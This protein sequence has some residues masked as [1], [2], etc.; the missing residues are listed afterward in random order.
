VARDPANTQWQRDVS[1]SQ[2]RIGTVLEAQGDGPGALA[3]YR[4]DLAI[5]EGLAA[6]D[7]ANAGWQVDVALSCAK[8]GA[9]EAGQTVDQRRD[10][11]TRGR[12]ILSELKAQ[13]RLSPQRD[14]IAWF[15]EQLANL[16][17]HSASASGQ[18]SPS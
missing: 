17:P 14:M 2:N 18:P 15:D 7:P 6:R 1:V 4:K 12:R 8:L 9:L 16:P 13:G 11:L 10:Y 3:A 5:A